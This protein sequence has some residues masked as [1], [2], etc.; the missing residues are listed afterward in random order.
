MP[1]YQLSKRD[2]N[3]PISEGP[4]YTDHQASVPVSQP[5]T[6]VVEVGQ[7]KRQ[8]HDST[9]PFSS[10]LSDTLTTPDDGGWIGGVGPVCELGLQSAMFRGL[11]VSHGNR[12]LLVEE[13]SVSQRD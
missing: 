8:W 13:W 7:L 5:E 3:A 11:Y 2:Y 4:I 10:I 1:G 9:P 12:P 6:C